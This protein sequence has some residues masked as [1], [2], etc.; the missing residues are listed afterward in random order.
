MRLVSS[1]FC[2]VLVA[3]SFLAQA[4]PAEQVLATATGLKFTQSS[5]SENGR[6]LFAE[7]NAIL[8]AER[9]KLFAQMAAD[10]LMEFEAK[11]RGVTRELLI[12]SEAR[13]AADPT[14]AEIKSVFDANRA[15]FSDR[16]I[17][18]MRPQI[19]AYLRNN[20]EQKVFRDLVESLK[21][22]YKYTAGKD[23]NSPG[24]KPPDTLFSIIGKTVSAQEF[25][26]SY[27]AA[28]YEARAEIA[29]AIFADL[30][31]AILST[32]VS[33]EAKSRNLD[34]GDL[35]AAEITSKMR[36][37]SDAE[38]SDLESAF[39]KRLFAKFDVKVLL[40]EPEPVA[41]NISADDD[42]ATG[43]PTAPV[44]VI[45]FSDF[46]CSACSAT[47]PI[48][49]KAIAEFGAKVRFVVR[50]FPLESIHEHAFRS[51]LAANAARAQGKYFEYIDILYRNQER[52][53][54]ASLK[55]YAAELGLNAK[56]FELDF[57]SEKT[58]AEVRKDMSDGNSYGTRGTPAIFVNGVRINRLSADSFR[59]AI[60]KALARAASK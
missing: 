6:K 58:A 45:M 17:D 52:L 10:T 30:E 12:D 36:D 43:S 29:E 19:V 16:T 7:Q 1:L 39:Q 21:G 13:K 54:D 56:Q 2:I 49:K 27:K 15:N 44:T 22:K 60:S 3:S 51:A 42:P 40:A 55:R 35:I 50:D 31:A 41:R 28:I 24:L 57:S 33:V 48:L 34:T 11:S 37:F 38:R 4:P 46:Q 26:L 25:D 47:H 9:S 18:Q 53:D 23:V 59:N 5:L 32:L 14:E 20:A 8:A